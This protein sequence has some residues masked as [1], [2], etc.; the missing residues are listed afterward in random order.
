MYF[1]PTTALRDVT[2]CKK[3]QA[4]EFYILEYYSV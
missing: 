2:G 3:L 4:E 1:K